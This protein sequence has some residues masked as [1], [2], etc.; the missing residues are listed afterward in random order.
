MSKPSIHELPTDRLATTDELGRRVYLYPADVR[1]KYRSMRSWLSA[2]LILVFLVMPWIKIQGH[3]AVLLDIPHRRFALFGLTFWAHEAPMLFFV[4]AIAVL[5][6]FLVT[7][8]WGRVWCGW[9]CPQTVF[10]DAV[11][12]KIERWVEGDGVTRRRLD[13]APWDGEK[14]LKKSLKWGLFSAVSLVLS[15]SFLAYFVGPEELGRMM[16]SS[17]ADSPAGQPA[18]HSDE[19]AYSSAGSSARRSISPAAGP[20]GSGH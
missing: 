4:A 7:S 18:S 17:P 3:P 8:I 20:A 9:A 10:V 12:R 13:Q 16:L 14:A 1:G 11:F 5:T 15:H 2:V 19:C 6:L